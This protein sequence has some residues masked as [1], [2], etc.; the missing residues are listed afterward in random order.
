MQLIMTMGLELLQAAPLGE[1]EFVFTGICG[2]ISL[3]YIECELVFLFVYLF[4]TIN[5]LFLSDTF[6]PFLLKCE[7]E[8]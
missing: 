8:G 2:D 5:S 4:V 1:H 7:A 3:N 6:T